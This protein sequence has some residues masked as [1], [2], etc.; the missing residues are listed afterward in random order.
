[1]YIS[2]ENSNASGFKRWSIDHPPGRNDDDHSG[3]ATPIP[4]AVPD[5][6]EAMM[7]PPEQP[8]RPWIVPGMGTL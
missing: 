5:L 2:L 1:M 4:V 6:D 7:A 8:H 3:G